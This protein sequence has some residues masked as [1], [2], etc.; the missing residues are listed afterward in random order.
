MRKIIKYL[1]LKAR[2]IKIYLSV[3]RKKQKY[4][5]VSFFKKIKMKIK[6]FKPDHYIQYDFKNNNPK[7]Y[8][9]ETDRWKTRR[10]NGSLNI[11]F[12]DKLIFYNIFS[13][14]LDIPKNLS[15]IKNQVINNFKGEKLKVEGLVELLKLNQSVIIKPNRGAGG[16]GV[17]LVKYVNDNFVNSNNKEIS[18]DELYKNVIKLDDYIITPLVEQADYA[19]KLYDKTTNTIRIITIFDDNKVEVPLAVHRIGTKE[20]IPADNAARG[21]LFSFVNIETGELS[22]AL[23][24]STNKPIDY[25]PDSNTKITGTIIPGW[26]KLKDEVTSIHYKFPYI[27]FMAWDIVITKQGWTVLEINASTDLEMF[28]MFKPQKHTKLGNFYRKMKVIK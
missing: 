18:Y 24:Y 17:F 25:H 23:N 19:N 27:P 15:W 20:S 8:L 7:H 3:F 21:G 6:G 14:H 12:D 11:I 1:Q 5:R 26:K 10:V 22:Y 4:Y 28:Q 13:N 2:N 16:K 9:N